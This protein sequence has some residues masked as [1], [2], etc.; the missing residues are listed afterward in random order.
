ML[1]R[2]QARRQESE[3]ELRR[4]TRALITLTN[5][6]ETIMR[7]TGKKDFLREICR[8]IVKDGGYR[9]AWV[10]FAEQ[11][12]HKTV[13]PIAQFGYEE[14]YL[15][16]I[17]ITW[18]DTE[19]GRGPTG[20]AI[21]KGRPV[22][23][24]DILTDRQYGPWRAEATKRGYASSIALPLKGEKGVFGSLNI[25]SSEPD[26]F[27]RKEV[28]LL[29]ELADDIGYGIRAL[30]INS[31]SKKAE[32]ELKQ[33]VEKL[34]KV[35]HGTVHALAEILQ[36][37]DPYT[38]DHQERVAQLACAIAREMDLSE[39]RIEGIL[40]AGLLHDIGKINVPSEI[41]AR[42]GQMSDLE[43]GI[44]ETHAQVGYEILKTIEFPWPVAETVLQHQERM[45][46]SGYPAGLSGEQILLEARILAVADVVEAMSSHRPYRPTLGMDRALKQ[47][48]KNR[49]VLYDPDV[50]DACLRLFTKKGYT[51]EPSELNLTKFP[52]L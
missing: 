41:L 49:G 21:R 38:A 46:G 23:I 13:H 43:T 6:N 48:K 15:D 35:L 9:L 4:V 24:R 32:E 29:S 8:I 47:I 3:R 27:D 44:I 16:T 12:K 40:M 11:D 39:D 28:K 18:S 42:P 22:I 37:R 7:A 36:R 33:S 14:G 51:L 52:G 34:K 31:R 25:Y 20:T 30:E 1:E 10:G 50:V 17:K 5:C 45:D 2:K 19:T 26:A